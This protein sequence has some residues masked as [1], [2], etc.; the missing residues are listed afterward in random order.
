MRGV[1]TVLISLD[2]VAPRF[3]TPERMPH[4]TGL[5]RAGAGCFTATTVDPPWTRPAHASMLRGVGPGTHGLVDNSVVPLE[6]S[7]PS[8]LQWARD[9]DRVT[10]MAVNWHAM[11]T[12]VEARAAT[13][14][15][16]IDGGY[17]P[18]EDDRMVDHLL[19]LVGTAPAPDLV[20]AYLARPDL[21]GHDHG[22]GSPPYLEALALVDA[23]L[24]RLL[25]GFDDDTSIL[26]T[27]DHGGVGTDHGSTA[28]E[29]M[30]TFVAAR[31]PMIPAGSCW[32]DA[33]MLDVAPTVAA[34]AGLDPAPAWEGRS[35]LGTE[36]PFL[37]V[38]VDLLAE[39]DAVT[40]GERC[41][42]RAHQ[43]QT[44]AA[45]HSAGADDD[46][47]VA[48]LLHDV[49]HLLGE[50]GE[51]GLPD[52]AEV[53]ARWLGPWLPEPVVAP[54]RLHVA[55]KRHLVAVDPAYAAELSEASTITLAQQGGPFDEAG[56][57][58][59]LAEPHA[60]RAMALR[61]FDDLGKAPD[62]MPDDAAVT[63]LLARVLADGPIDP[64]WARHAC[65][66]ADCVDAGSGQRLTEPPDLV[67]WTVRASTVEPDGTL[68]VELTRG[69]E[70]HDAVI[71]PAAP[72][73]GLDPVTWDGAHRP[74]ARDASELDAVADDLARLGLAVLAGAPTEP[75][76]VLD[77]AAS[78]GF[79]RETNY[80]EVFDVRTEPEPINLAYSARGLGLH[81]DNPYRDPSPTV[82]LLHCLRPAR[83]GGASRVSDGFAAAARLRT[84]APEAF[85]L[86]TSTPVTFRF[87]SA[88]VDLCATRP[89][90]DLDPDGRV[91]SVAVNP[92][93][94]ADDLDTA[95]VA[96]LARFT[97]LLDAGAIEHLLAAGEVLL[98]DN[99]RVLHAR[100]EFDPSDGRHLQGCYIDID[101]VESR[102]R[103]AGA[104]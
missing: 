42:M 31:S 55:A 30:T 13:H 73:A 58:A 23:T 76:T 25:A 77:I 79:V 87:R 102:A 60:E 20:F 98:V 36:R 59:F 67:G 17:D 65:R 4:L 63:S 8:I 48:A 27:T 2:G 53:A 37:D 18:A 104:R 90:I 52:H 44:A 56:S 80:G 14:R 15:F 93:S 62:A 103:L 35:L 34:L 12:L 64:A 41:S 66:C 100:T 97:E 83:T 26:V 6:T 91:V 45:A 57:A 72:H 101:A 32:S 84:D 46:L 3:I 19:Q 71:P 68:L 7:A 49:G 99:R 75:G 24:G 22:W 39:A 54:I 33:S 70:T 16:V 38:L 81:T 85:E 1:T 21:A 47:V 94:L 96:A 50:A 69:D 5:A 51:W 29:V 28:P 11:D 89:M 95:M 88:E 61:R 78:L 9:H 43:L 82:Q 92:R 10:A 86:L 74:L 40:Y